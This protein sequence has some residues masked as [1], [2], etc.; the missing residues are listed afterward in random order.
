VETELVAD[1]LVIPLGSRAVPSTT[2]TSTRVRST[3]R[4]KAWPSLPRRTRPRSGGDVGHRRPALV[5]GPQDP[6]PEVR[7]ER[8]ERVSRRSS[9]RRAV[10]AGEQRRLAR[11]R[12]PH[13]A[14][15]GDQPQL[16]AEPALLARLALLGMAW[17]L[18]RRRSEV[19][20]AQPPRPPRATSARWPVRDQLVGQQRPAR[21]VE[22]AGPGGTRPGRVGT[23]L[24][25]AARPAAAPTR[26]GPEVM[27]VAEVAKG[28]QTESTTRTTSRPARPRRPSAAPRA[29]T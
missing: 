29:G 12:Q 7:F 28:R 21:V 9:R 15:I 18:V 14:D 11:V 19:D 27:P 23:G 6:S 13:Q 8:R 5:V 22:D 3:W 10:R 25:V 16:Q 2:W 17:R 20:V 1:H 4:R 24:P 26:L